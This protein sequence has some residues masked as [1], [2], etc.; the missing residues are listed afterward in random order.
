MK[1]V[2]A[3]G[4][5]PP[6]PDPK[7]RDGR[8][9]KDRPFLKKRS[10]RTLRRACRTGQGPPAHRAVQPQQRPA[11]AADHAGPRARIRRPDRAS[12]PVAQ[13]AAG[14]CRTVFGPVGASE[15]PGPLGA[16]GAESLA[17]CRRATG[18][19][20]GAAN[21]MGHWAGGGAGRWRHLLGA[22]RL[23]YTQ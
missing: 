16:R 19:W 13:P 22:V 1:G 23:L 9:A 18:G 3:L 14:P 10:W 12:P 4:G 11:P 7:A 8:P 5:S 2:Q 21:V 17:E 6:R 15:R 20:R